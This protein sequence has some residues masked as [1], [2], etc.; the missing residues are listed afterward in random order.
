MRAI[1][2]IL[3]ALAAMIALPLILIGVAIGVIAVSA[4]AALK[5]GVK[6]VPVVKPVDMKAPGDP[7]ITAPINW[8]TV[9]VGRMDKGGTG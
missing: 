2:I 8:N 1:K 5:M 4:R 6:P 3:T 9:P 7:E